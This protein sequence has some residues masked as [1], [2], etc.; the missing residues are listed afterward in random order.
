MNFVCFT[1]RIDHAQT[2]V[3]CKRYYQYKSVE[4]KAKMERSLFCTPFAIHLRD[5]IVVY[6]VHTQGSHRTQSWYTRVLKPHSSLSCMIICRYNLI[7]YSKQCRGNEWIFSS[8]WEISDRT[9]VRFKRSMLREGP[10]DWLITMVKQALL[11]QIG[12]K[13][14]MIQGWLGWLSMNTFCFSFR[15]L[16]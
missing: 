4:L 3:K 9:E 5:W 13:K 2:K 15:V 7:L 10:I 8:N 16:D 12:W 6:T 11:S 14:L 1:Y